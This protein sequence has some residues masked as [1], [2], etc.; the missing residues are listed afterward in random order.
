MVPVSRTIMG[1]PASAV[2]RNCV[3][4][5]QRGLDPQAMS[6]A[7]LSWRRKRFSSLSRGCDLS[8][9]A[10]ERCPTGRGVRYTGALAEGK[11]GAQGVPPLLA[12]SHPFLREAIE[13]AGARLLYLPPYSPDLAPTE[14]CWSKLKSI[15]R[16]AKARTRDVLD[17]AIAPALATITASDARG[18]F[19][20]CGCL[21]VIQ[22]S[23]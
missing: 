9:R 2:P 4:P 14:R 21:T 8:R 18:W 13:R 6:C 22:E 16:T 17:D 5:G 15:L 20:R 10:R 1:G 7:M 3:S 12:P 11:G 23:L 19:Q